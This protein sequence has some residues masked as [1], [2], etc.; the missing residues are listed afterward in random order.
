MKVTKLDNNTIQVEKEEVKTSVKRYHYGFLLEQRKSIEKQA[1][2][3]ADA[4]Q[5]ELDEIDLLI[6]EADKLGIKSI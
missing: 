3:F 1:K 4:R 2:E 5:L 6:S